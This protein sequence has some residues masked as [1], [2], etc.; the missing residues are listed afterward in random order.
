[1]HIGHLKIAQTLSKEFMLDE[2]VFVPAYHA[3]H[4]RENK[5]ASPFHRFAMLTAV[6]ADEPS[7]IVSSIEL[8]DPE[9][10]YSIETLT[11]IKSLMPDDEILFVI[12]ADSWEDITTWRRWEEVLTIV[13]V[14][15]VTR[16]G[17]EIGFAHVTDR[18]RESVVDL[19]GR[20]SEVRILAKETRI[21]ITDCVNID[22][23]ATGIRRM[24]RKGEP[25]WEALVPG[26]AK[27]HIEKYGLY[28]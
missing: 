14:I 12:G 19:R 20:E 1:M 27:K 4:K 28:R 15:V 13:N 23:S 7:I 26:P 5:P 24:V 18:I 25:G 16:P 11:K 17:Y 21:Y 9:R 3:P 10:P 6:T 22:A 8:E 2:F